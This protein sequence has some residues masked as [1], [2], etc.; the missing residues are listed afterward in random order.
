L[1]AANINVMT[2]MIR[3]TAGKWEKV[4]KVVFADEAELQALLYSSAELIPTRIEGLA[5]VFT[6]EAGLPGSG[7]T[8]LIGVDAHGDILIV[9]TKLARNS[10]IR[11]K[12]IGQV[13]EYAAYLWGMSFDDF[14]RFFRKRED[15]PVAELLYEKDPSLDKEQFKETVAA[16]LKSGRFRL[17][18]AVD[19]INP[20]LEK[21]IAYIS[22]RGSGV[23]LEALELEFYR[24][25]ATEV[26]VPQRYGQ[27]N[28]PRESP[29]GRKSLSFQEVLQNCQ[30]DHDR[31]L[32]RMLGELWEAED[33]A[34]KP[35]TVGAS[36]QAQI[37][38]RAQPIFWAFPDFLQNNL[39]DLSKRG[40]PEGAVTI[41]RQKV[42]SLAGFNREDIQNRSQPVTKFS[43]LSESAVRAF[44]VE[45]QTLVEA[46]RTSTGP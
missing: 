10:E 3:N 14:D 42:A 29:S 43:K 31:D 34:V 6:R 37:L 1:V 35:G 44:I 45:T 28:Q 18:I 23:E 40:A 39:S 46:W 38:G 24:N 22:S 21:V 25:G 20:E 17:I 26:V 13:L 27:L 41:Y 4:E 5:A 19:A 2:L 32:L 36:F 33:N 8:D 9:E 15:R 16:N 30:N 11:R 7:F 12:V